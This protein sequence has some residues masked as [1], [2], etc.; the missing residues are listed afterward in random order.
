[1]IYRFVG[2][3]C[4]AQVKHKTYQKIMY[5]RRKDIYTPTVT[6]DL[7]DGISESCN[8]TQYIISD[9]RLSNSDVY[10]RLNFLDLKRS[11]VSI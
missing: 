5:Q 9:F 2:V 11:T 7:K 6:V 4:I 3:R 10:G 8:V 1:M